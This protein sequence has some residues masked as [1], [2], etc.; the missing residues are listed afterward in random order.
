[1]EDKVPLVLTPDLKKKLQ[2]Q[3]NFG[4]QDDFTRSQRSKKGDSHMH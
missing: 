2:V 4:I 3:F 1:M